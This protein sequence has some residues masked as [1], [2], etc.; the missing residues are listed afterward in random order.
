VITS[1]VGT[2]VEIKPNTAT[3]R[4][5]IKISDSNFQVDMSKSTLRTVLGFNAT[6]REGKPNILEMGSV[7]SENTV[8]IIDIAS[9][10]VHCNLAT[11]YFHGD[12]SSVLY[13]FFPTV[14]IGHKIIQRPS[15]PLYL[16][17]TKRGSINRIRLWIT[18]QTGT[19]CDF[20]DEN[21]TVRLHIRSI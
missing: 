2:V 10:L 11:S 14:G 4:S 12:L 9:I 21:I 8:N 16:P 15:Q 1:E 7:E 6:T 13:S 3:L 19:L 5:I 20:R 17:I 18:S